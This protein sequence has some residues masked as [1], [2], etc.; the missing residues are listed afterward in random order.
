MVF[1]GTCIVAV[2]TRVWLLSCV[3]EKMSVHIAFLTES[4]VT[5]SAR[6]WSFSR[7]DNHMSSE[8][9]GSREHFT[10]DIA[11]SV[12]WCILVLL[13]SSNTFL[14]IAVAVRCFIVNDCSTCQLITVRTMGRWFFRWIEF[15]EVLE[16][17]GRT[18]RNFLNVKYNNTLSV[19]IKNALGPCLVGNGHQI[20]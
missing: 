13:W 10:T 14:L 17:L 5:F 15:I 2:F 18:C 3:S 8:K 6:K 9:R 19:N 7:M 16:F 1:L 20:K 11:C 12:V 4:F